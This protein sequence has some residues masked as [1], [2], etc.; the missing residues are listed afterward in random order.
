MLIIKHQNPFSQM[1]RG[2]FSLQRYLT[3]RV[4]NTDV[5]TLVGCLALS[6]F[7]KSLIVDP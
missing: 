5:E 7:C 2:P 4:T 3:Q 6:V 1:A